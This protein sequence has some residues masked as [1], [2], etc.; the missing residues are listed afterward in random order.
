[1]KNISRFAMGNIDFRSSSERD[2][3]ILMFML[4]C[5]VDIVK[6]KEPTRCDK[7]FSFIAYSPLINLPNPPPHFPSAPPSPPKLTQHT[8][9]LSHI[10]PNPSHSVST[11]YTNNLYTH[12]QPTIHARVPSHHRQTLYSL[13]HYTTTHCTKTLE[14]TILHIFSRYGHLKAEVIY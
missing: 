3:V 12:T 4:Q 5:I 10:L 14:L 1:M 9:K 13:N 8:Q 2:L 6:G 7:V 11:Q